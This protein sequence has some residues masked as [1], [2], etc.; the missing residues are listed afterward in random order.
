MEEVW[1]PIPGFPNYQISNLGRIYN[2]SQDMIMSSAPN[3]FGNHKI[4]LYGIDGKR[5]TRSVAYFVAKAFVRPPTGLCTQVVVLDGD[6]NNLAAENLAWR[7]NWFAWR[8][9][10]QLKVHQPI[11]HRNLPVMNVRS[12][13]VYGNVVE[14]G[15]AEGLLFDDIWRSTYTGAEIFPGNH[16]FV[17]ATNDIERVIGV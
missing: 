9:T 5:Y 10:H 17:I 8:Y 2:Q 6:F 3:N 7:P 1:K 15:I 12:G 4:S 16:V 11:Y 13:T 14:A